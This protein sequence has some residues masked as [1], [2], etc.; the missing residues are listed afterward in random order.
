MTKTITNSG[1]H[2]W[3]PPRLSITLPSTATLSGTASDP[4]SPTLIADG[5]N[6]TIDFLFYP[7]KCDIQVELDIPP[8][9]RL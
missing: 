6:V 1:N 4:W 7:L 2:R 9:L 3:A 5:P 8:S